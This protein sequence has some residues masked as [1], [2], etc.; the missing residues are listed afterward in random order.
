MNEIA[1]KL[2]EITS[3]FLIESETGDGDRLDVSIGKIRDALFEAYAAGEAAKSKELEPIRAELEA[4]KA[5]LEEFK[6]VY[7]EDTIITLH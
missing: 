5:E 6:N 2:E 7:A 3:K 4:I 1:K